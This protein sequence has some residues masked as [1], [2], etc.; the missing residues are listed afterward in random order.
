MQP[1]L[2]LQSITLLTEFIARKRLS[3][4]RVRLLVRASQEST[5]H[6]SSNKTADVEYRTGK[7][8][9]CRA[10]S[11]SEADSRVPMLLR[12]YGLVS[13]TSSKQQSHQISDMLLGLVLEASR[14]PMVEGFASI[15]TP[16]VLVSWT[17]S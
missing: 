12:K 10:N 15:I 16:P 9:C 6:E 2:A 8:L 1:A 4:E 17:F 5:G 14:R 11:Q 13:V 7:C 3:P